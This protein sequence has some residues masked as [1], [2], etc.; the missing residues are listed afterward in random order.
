[1][2]RRAGPARARVRLH[3]GD[4]ALRVEVVDDGIG[5]AMAA[6]PAPTGGH[7][8]VA[9]RE[10]VALVGGTL[11]VGPQPG[12]GWVVSAALPLAG[13]PTRVSGGRERL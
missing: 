13:Q 4:E 10:R 1:M 8:L 5:S 9:M 6:P 12:R 3:Y 2:S 7:G 11:T